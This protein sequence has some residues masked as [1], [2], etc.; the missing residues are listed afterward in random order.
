MTTETHAHIPQKI[1]IIASGTGGHIIPALAVAQCLATKPTELHWLGTSHGLEQRLV[2]T[3]RIT[4]HAIQAYGVR[5]KGLLGWSVAPLRM[6]RA[7]W[8]A[9]RILK[10]IRPTVV[11]GFGGF[12]TLPAGLAARWLGIPLIIQEQ[13]AI[14]GWSNKLLAVLAIQIYEGFPHTFRHAV[15]SGNP[16]RMDIVQIPPP[17]QRLADRQGPLRLLICGGSQGA[18]IFNRIL[19]EALAQFSA[20]Q[21]PEVWHSAGKNQAATTAAAYRELGIKSRVVEFIDDM[22]SAYAWA[23][24]VICRAGALTIAELTAAGVGSILIP[25]PFAAGDHQ[26]KN[27]AWLVNGQAALAIRQDN[28]QA[29]SLANLLMSLQKDRS[30][31]LAMAEAA[32]RLA[33]PHAA[34]T[35]AEGVFTHSRQAKK[36]ESQLC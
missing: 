34:D 33:M 21:C 3:D 9:R 22:A 12:V 30:R 32:R 35:V 17:M 1:L 6:L 15:A 16:V 25:Y 7:F 8:Q 29:Q 11:V 10:Q 36:R 31:L 13:N 20:E 28:L 4:M 24:L 23:D 19:P 26:S 2:P 18:A 27:A 5:G 14:A